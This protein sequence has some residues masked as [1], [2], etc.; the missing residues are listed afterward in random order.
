MFV[1]ANALPAGA[2]TAADVCIVGAGAAG[3]TL[4]RT[5]ARYGVTTALL[6]SG[7]LT[8][9]VDT[10]RLYDVVNADSRYWFQNDTTGD[11][12]FSTLRLRYFGGSTNHWA[13]TCRPL[14]AED[15]MPRP[16]VE[17]SGWP[18]TRADLDTYY[19]EA[20]AILDLPP[21]LHGLSYED[22]VGNPVRPPRLLPGNGEFTPLAWFVSPPTRMNEKYRGEIGANDRIRCILHA[23][24]TDIGT[25]AN[26]THVNRIRVSTLAG[27]TSTVTA[28]AY[29]LCTGG[30]ENARLLLLS[31]SVVPG[32]I[33]NRHDL[34]GRYLME[35]PSTPFPW[36]ALRSPDGAEQYLEEE[37]SQRSG[38]G[39][40]PSIKSDFI[41]FATTPAFRRKHRL[42]AC[43]I[44]AMRATDSDLEQVPD[45]I[46]TLLNASPRASGARPLRLYRIMVLAEQAPNPNSR[47]TLGTELDALGQR[48]TV[49]ALECLDIDRRNVKITLAHFARAVGA[50][51]RGRLQVVE[52]EP[53]LL[54]G[55]G[56][57][58]GTTRMADDPRRG[59][60]DRHARVH[61]VD[62]LYVA[63]SSL[64]PT[65]GFANPTLTLVALTLRLA[66]RLKEVLPSMAGP[67]SE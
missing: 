30:I 51:G 32:G 55:G 7:G 25:D 18:I 21:L 33:G 65:V 67:A 24:A 59:V 40:L 64:F 1:D 50:L 61:G 60:T 34:V 14:D 29:V 5:L 17:H 16:W 45:A 63:G 38:L 58:M 19:P 12:V 42:L 49:V 46:R 54:A 27:R 43:S 15:F 4:A 11:Y 2:H 23:N 20:M 57:D 10:Q 48:K 22:L 35:H 28:K 41:G 26:G 44:N 52:S 62:N 56:H 66:D 6:E 9:D 39:R 37:V 31:D 13:G 53:T 47:V 3:I 36:L 8:P